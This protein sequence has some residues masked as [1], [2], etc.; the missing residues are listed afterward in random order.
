MNKFSYKG[1]EVEIKNGKFYTKVSNGTLRIFKNEEYLKNFID[2]EAV[3][4]SHAQAMARL[5]W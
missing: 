2:N 4:E 5:A 1:K 3:L